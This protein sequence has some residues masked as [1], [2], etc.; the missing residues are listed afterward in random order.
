M[1]IHQS[2][3]NYPQTLLSILRLTMAFNHKTNL[4]WL[5][6]IGW[7]S[8][9]KIAPNVF[10]PTLNYTPSCVQIKRINRIF[11]FL[12]IGDVLCLTKTLKIKRI[13]RTKAKTRFSQHWG[14]QDFLL[15]RAQTHNHLYCFIGI[16]P[17]WCCRGMEIK[18]PYFINIRW[19]YSDSV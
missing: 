3:P 18:S 4:S 12:I 11:F 13:N 19:L 8:I 15:W 14:L 2:Q 9:S 5:S 1:C 17:Y 7:I 16:Y 6:T 10:T